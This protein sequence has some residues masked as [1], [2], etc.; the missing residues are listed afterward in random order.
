MR[1]AEQNARQGMKQL[2]ERFQ[3]RLAGREKQRGI[4]ALR[5]KDRASRFQRTGLLVRE[6]DDLHIAGVA[7]DLLTRDRQNIAE[8]APRKEDLLLPDSNDA[9]RRRHP[10]PPALVVGPTF[11]TRLPPPTRL[12]K[13][14]KPG[15]CFRFLLR[16]LEPQFLGDD[17][18]RAALDLIVD[19]A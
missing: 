10:P 16:L 12:V 17:I 5:R 6:R 3:R 2:S 13:L 18:E 1:R 9:D 7:D 19:P 11:E 15:V 8:V 4:D 14:A